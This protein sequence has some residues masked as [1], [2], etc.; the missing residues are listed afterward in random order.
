MTLKE[1]VIHMLKCALGPIARVEPFGSYVTKLD[2]R[3]DDIDLAVIFK[4]APGWKRN[5]KGKIPLKYV[6][7]KMDEIIAHLP[8]AKCTLNKRI[9]GAKVPIIRIWCLGVKV[10]LVLHD[11]HGVLMARVLNDLFLAFSDT[12]LVPLIRL[13]KRWAKS[14]NLIDASRGNFSDQVF[15]ERGRGGAYIVSAQ[16]HA[17]IHEEPNF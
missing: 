2:E 16:R 13:V 10:D 4:S 15:P 11:G 17:C 1:S 3:A 12:C 14:K 5:R 8:M 7:P 9:P 6:N